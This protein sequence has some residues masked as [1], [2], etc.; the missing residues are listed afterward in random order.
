MAHAAQSLNEQLAVC[1]GVFANEHLKFMVLPGKLTGCSGA[2]HAQSIAD[3]CRQQPEKK[4]KLGQYAV[5][6]QNG[7]PVQ[8]GGDAPNKAK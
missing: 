6:W 7:Q 5:I 1:G 8:M 4:Q 3:R 2:S